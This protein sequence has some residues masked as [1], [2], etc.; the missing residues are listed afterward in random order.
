MPYLVSLTESTSRNVSTVFK[1]AIPIS[2]IGSF[3]CAVVYAESK[4]IWEVIG[5]IGFEN[6]ILSLCWLWVIYEQ[7]K[8]RLVF[9]ENRV[10]QLESRFN[11]KPSE[12]HVHNQEVNQQTETKSVPF[13][14]HTQPEKL[15]DR[16]LTK[17][18]FEELM[19]RIESDEA[20]DSN[21]IGYRQHSPT[22]SPRGVYID[23]N[24]R[25][26]RFIG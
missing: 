8:R 15:E 3:A 17:D 16:E 4:N 9:T 18:Q 25:K 12:V 26:I 20:S 21:A 6:V 19:R 14:I 2:I 7:N 1:M 10:A 5:W 11:T 23:A 13:E 22:P 24:S